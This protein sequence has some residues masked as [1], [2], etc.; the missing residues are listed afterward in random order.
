MID[1]QV[2][3]CLL[4]LAALVLVATTAAAAAAPAP[5]LVLP[6]D[7]EARA[8]ALYVADGLRHQI[9][10][11]DLGKRKLTVFAGTGRAGTSGDGGR[12]TRARL[13]EPTELVFDSAGNLYFS[14]VNQGRV[15][16]IDRRGIITTVARVPAAAGLSVDPSGRFL[17]IASIEGWVYRVELPNGALERLAGDG[18]ETSSGNGGPASA[19]QLNGPHDVTY[20]TRGNLLVAE[21][22]GIRR[23]DAATG[24]ID[25][26]FTR[27]GFKIV[28]GAGGSFYLLDGNPSGGTVTQVDASG[29]VLR[30]IGTGK[31]G[32]HRDRVAIGSVGFLPS[33]VEP[34][35]GTLFISQT[36]PVPAIRRLAPG[37]KTL[38]TLVRY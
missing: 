35:G 11:Y 24:T 4:P 1:V 34:V 25:A 21:I 31:L 8:N 29:A 19:A 7:L 30:V 32:P 9:L 27:P 15:R 16:R 38:T 3:Q 33:D 26:A 14:D 17:A 22:G 37:S 13:T 12:A 18:T 36:Q 20:D 5:R 2:R 28:P 6:Y 10:R 23:I